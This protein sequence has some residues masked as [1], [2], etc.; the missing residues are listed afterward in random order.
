MLG[1]LA[2]SG[3]ISPNKYTW[4]YTITIMNLHDRFRMDF[5]HCGLLWFKFPHHYGDTIIWLT[6][7]F[8]EEGISMCTKR[9]CSNFDLINC[10]RRYRHYGFSP[11][12][13][14][15]KYLQETISVHLITPKKFHKQLGFPRKRLL[16]QDFDVTIM[17]KFR[18]LRYARQLVTNVCFGNQSS[19]QCLASSASR[20]WPLTWVVPGDGKG[21]YT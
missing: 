7:L 4:I 9:W 21:P 16:F 10:S 2:S 19:M 11:A 3:A 8:N 12:K 1:C 15:S 5:W 6:S 17:K 14:K 20:T 18:T 13:S